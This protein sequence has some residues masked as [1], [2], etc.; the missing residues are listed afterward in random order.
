MDGKDLIERTKAV[1]AKL[2]EMEKST[3][4]CVLHVL[5]LCAC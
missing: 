4:Q 1:E 3:A 2:V 5:D